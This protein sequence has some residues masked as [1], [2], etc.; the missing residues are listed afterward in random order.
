M[1]SREEIDLM[2]LRYLRDHGPDEIGIIDSE[3]KIAAALVYSDLKRQKLID[4][5]N[6]APGVV[7]WD[8]N[9]AGREKL[10][11]AP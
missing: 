10:E 2:A 5:V 4:C 6:P 11:S 3:E 7:L 9:D 1:S 8:I